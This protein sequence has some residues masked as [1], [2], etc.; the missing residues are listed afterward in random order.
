MRVKKRAKIHKNKTGMI[1]EPREIEYLE[2]AI[3][4]NSLFFMMFKNIRHRTLRNA[5]VCAQ[6]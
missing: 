6:I 5:R 3:V 2:T 4:L 1:G